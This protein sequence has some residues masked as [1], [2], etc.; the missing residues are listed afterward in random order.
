MN[1]IKNVFYELLKAIY[2]FIYFLGN[3]VC[4]IERDIKNIIKNILMKH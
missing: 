4:N 2:I 1:V 3:M